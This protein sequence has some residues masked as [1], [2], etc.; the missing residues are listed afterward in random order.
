[1]LTPQRDIAPIEAQPTRVPWP[2]LLLA[3]TAAGAL[4]LGH[5]MPLPWPGL[6][7]GAARFI[8]LGFGVIGIG[9]IAWAVLVMA[10]AGTTI[11]PTGKARALVTTG[12]FARLRNPIYVGDVLLLLA[13]AE[14]TKSIWFVLLAPLF[15]LLV[16][17]LQILPEE[18][19]LEALFGEEYR[20]YKERTRR[21]L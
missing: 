15:V 9:L 19:H 1:M 6:D 8:G 12:P 11:L 4:W 10:R 7:D 21:W 20:R 16:T 17:W 3:A 13:A 5:V 14:I 2:P 18:R